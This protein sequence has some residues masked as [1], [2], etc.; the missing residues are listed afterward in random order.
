MSQIMFQTTPVPITTKTLSSSFAPPSLPIPRLGTSHPGNQPVSVKLRRKNSTV[1][2]SSSSLIDG[3]DHSMAVL[4]RCF[5]GPSAL[6]SGS[7][8]EYGPL[9]KGQY[10]AFGAVTLEKGKLDMSQQQSESTP[11]VS[12]YLRFENS[13]H[14]LFYQ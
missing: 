13:F 9:M 11:E 7:T 5:K 6:P 10:G 8:A 4:E 2:C 12:C 1:T 3:G 14:F